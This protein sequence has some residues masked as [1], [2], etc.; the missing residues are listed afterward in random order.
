MKKLVVTFFGLSAAMMISCGDG[1]DTSS[2]GALLDSLA[3][4]TDEPHVVP[5]EPTEE[6]LLIE[7][8][9]Q[10]IPSPLE[11][12]ILIK[13]SGAE[14]SEKYINDTKKVSSYA[15]GPE[16]AFNMGIYGADLGYANLYEKNVVSADYLKVVV[17]LADELKI[18]QF[19]DFGAL[20]KLAQNKDNTEE[21][22]NMSQS[23]FSDINNY[24]REKKRGDISAGILVG[25]WIE[26]LY[27]SSQV[28]HGDG[29]SHKAL[30]ERIGE[31][32]L[33]LEDMILITQKYSFKPEFAEAIKGLEDLKL[34]YENVTLE[35]VDSGEDAEP[36]IDENGMLVVMTT[37]TSV[38]T[39]TDEDLEKITASAKRLRDKLTK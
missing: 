10:S 7:G 17:D 8:I 1:T 21:L 5:D 11:M 20:A 27:L 25:G 4:S 26:S 36:Q 16:Q 13:E 6:D 30:L 29:A 14:F 31:Q 28:A 39:I 19:F 35:Y 3:S 38:V 33:I 24:L 12:A 9:M 2:T 34:A 18:G 22:I 23:S 15:T 37:T 32:K